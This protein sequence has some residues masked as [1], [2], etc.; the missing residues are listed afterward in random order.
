M[1]PPLDTSPV[2]GNKVRALDKVLAML[3]TFPYSAVSLIW[4]A[5]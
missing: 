3:K 4:M 2:G 5:L 1:R